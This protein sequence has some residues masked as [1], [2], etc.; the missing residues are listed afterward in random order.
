MVSFAKD[1]SAREGAREHCICKTAVV[2]GL[3]RRDRGWEK[4]GWNFE[5]SVL[6]T[7]G[8]KGLQ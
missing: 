3:G 5:G 2:A 8:R 6:V 7:L 4:L 1:S